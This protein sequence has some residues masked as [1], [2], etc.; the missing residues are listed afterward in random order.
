MRK[1]RTIEMKELEFEKKKQFFIS[2][3]ID[4]IDITDIYYLP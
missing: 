2:N 1:Y 3:I 4:I